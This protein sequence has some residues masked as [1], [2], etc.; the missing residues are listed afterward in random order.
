MSIQDKFIIKIKDQATEI[1]KKHERRR[2]IN[3]FLKNRW[4]LLLFLLLFLVCIMFPTV[5]GTSIG[6]WINNFFGS[7]YKNSIIK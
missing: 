2:R 1:A 6:T 3:L 7:I 5:V 4:K